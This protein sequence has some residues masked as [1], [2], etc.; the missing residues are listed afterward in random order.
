MLHLFSIFKQAST[1]N[2]IVDHVTVLDVPWF[3]LILS[4]DIF[5]LVCPKRKNCITS[6][7]PSQQ[8]NKAAVRN[9]WV[10]MGSI[11]Q[12]P[13]YAQDLSAVCVATYTAFQADYGL[14]RKDHLNLQK[15]LS[16]FNKCAEINR[17]TVS[18]SPQ[19]EQRGSIWLSSCPWLPWG[20]HSCQRLTSSGEG[21]VS[22]RKIAK[23]FLC[24]S[25]SEHG[26]YGTVQGSQG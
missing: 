5:S 24:H 14:A 23:F 26:A 10:T 17:N 8:N 4:Q 13:N 18:G 12:L 19:Q 21:P 20:T 3:W 15:A 11:P 9:E 22:I 16:L 25:L 6:W 1:K 2:K 7:Q